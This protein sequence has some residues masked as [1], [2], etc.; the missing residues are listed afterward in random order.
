[1]SPFSNSPD[2]WLTGHLRRLHQIDQ[3][4]KIQAVVRGFLIRRHQQKKYEDVIL[5]LQPPA[6]PVCLVDLMRQLRLDVWADQLPSAV[7]ALHDPAVAQKR[8][9][10]LWHAGIAL[11]LTG[12]GAYVTD[13]EWADYHERSKA[14]AHL[15]IHVHQD[16]LWERFKKLFLG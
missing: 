6:K 3:V 9:D 13:L 14:L 1:M 5:R 10:L 2:L 8:R 12:Q 7:D 16:S 11:R 4:T 15:D